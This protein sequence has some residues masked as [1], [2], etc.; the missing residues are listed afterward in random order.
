M[1]RL[2]GAVFAAVLLLGP[3]AP[4]RAWAETGE[5]HLGVQ[6]G[7][8]Y[9]PVTIAAEQGLIE[10]RAK[11]LGIEGL[12]VTLD[13]F[14]GSTAVIDVV[15]SG[16]IQL[17]AYGL[18]GLLI[19]WDK[20]QGHQDVRGLGAIGITAFVVVTNKPAI[21]TLKDFTDQNRIALPATNSPQAIILKMAA[22][23][24]YGPD[25][26]THFD[27]MMVALP[28]PD[29]ANAL[30]SGQIDGYV[31]TPPFQQMVLRDAR[32]H[33]VARSREFTGGQDATG[34]ILG[35]NKKFADDN[36]KLTQ[37]VYLGLEDAMAFIHAN[38]AE[39]A[40]IYIASEKSKLPK[41]DVETMLTDGSTTF[42]IRPHGLK[43]F[44][45]FMLKI[46]MLKQSPKDWKDTFFPVA[47]QNGGD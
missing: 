12:K 11:A 25:K 34:V 29:A 42:D 6:F 24:L 36:P 16:N 8:I 45:D 28:H 19:A 30:L 35:G 13:R 7:L 46:G 47:Y 23:Q 33:E 2:T 38:T 32:I 26:Y 44:A 17:G 27:T 18:P 1:K 41:Q 3:G 9:L 39:A 4:S 10:K 37:A 14:S 43:Q 31:S 15:M 21:K 40:D 20:T 22:A 5:L